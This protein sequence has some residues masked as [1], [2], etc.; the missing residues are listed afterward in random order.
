MSDVE[1]VPV[2]FLLRM[3][4]ELGTYSFLP[5]GPHGTRVFAPVLSGTVD[6]PRLSAAVA[7]GADWVTMRGDGWAHIDVRLVLTTPDGAVVAM[8]YTGLLG[9]DMR[10]RISATFQ[11]GADDLRW[12]NTIVAVGYGT[13][14]DGGVTYDIYALA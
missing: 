3:D 8:T 1:S 11:A 14:R 13:P 2:E 9:P 12:L 4:L 6:G 10:P 7:P 5:G